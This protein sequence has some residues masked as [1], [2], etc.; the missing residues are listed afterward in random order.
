MR[1]FL[2]DA[3]LLAAADALSNNSCGQGDNVMIKDCILEP[4]CITNESRRSFAFTALSALTPET[5]TSPENKNILS[6]FHSFAP[7]QPT[8]SS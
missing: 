7:L 3:P 4:G 5:L 8:V 2:T 1:D 6:L